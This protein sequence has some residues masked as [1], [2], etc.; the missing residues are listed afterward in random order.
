MKHSLLLLAAATIVAPAMMA[1]HAPRPSVEILDLPSGINAVS[2]AQGFVDVSPNASPRG[3]GEITFTFSRAPEINR[4]CTAEAKCW[5]NGEVN[6]ISTATVANAAV[7]QMGDPTAS[8]TF[9]G[10]LTKPGTYHV[11]I[12]AGMFNVNGAASPAVAL[13]YEI[14]DLYS[15]TPA[16]GVVDKL[17][18]IHLLFPHAD[19]VRINRQSSV[20]LMLVGSDNMY[21]LGF[22]ITSE[23]PDGPKN[24]VVMTV[25]G[26]ITTPGTYLFHC[27]S[28]A[29]SAITYGPN[30]DTDPTDY[31]VWDTSE[32]V[33]HYQV[34]DFPAPEIDPEE[35]EVYSFS[36]FTLTLPSDFQLFMVDNM[37]T[38]YIYPLLPDGNNG[39]EVIARVKASRDWDIADKVFLNVVGDEPVKPT[40]G[41]YVLV[42]SNA[43][44]SGMY[45]G[46]F[47]NTVSY[48]YIYNVVAD[49]T[50]VTGIRVEKPVLQG[51]YTLDGKR[52]PEDATLPAGLYI[53]D[54][55]KTLRK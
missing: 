13:N 5:Y 33:R 3:V 14:Y 55:K 7:D 15:L 30:Y 34:A 48:R 10:P 4:S 11:E 8:V 40:P 50:S 39:P 25:A 22:N 27:V 46:N 37:T 12:P 35:G 38:S 41:E 52:L 24:L 6:P 29:F 42:L 18:E 20:E 21:P 45:N 43:L 31:T 47:V 9:A 23:K 2:P 49:P 16:P 17:S 44:I 51:I 19:E 26:G 36:K 28:D 32:I 53:I 1:Q 54:G